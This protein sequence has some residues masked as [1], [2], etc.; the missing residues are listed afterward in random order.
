MPTEQTLETMPLAD[1]IERPDTAAFII[2]FNALAKNYIA[3]H[4]YMRIGKVL[5]GNY[6][7]GYVQ[8]DR[9][10][11]ILS[12]LGTFNI[13]IFP[14]VCGLHA[15]PELDAS[16]ITAVQQQPFLDLR[17]RGVL[18]GFV[19]T[20]IDYTQKAFQYEDGTTKI[21]YIWD[22]TIRGS[23]PDGYNL[24]AEYTEAQINE[25]INSAEPYSVVPHRDTVGHGTFL[26]SVAA[27]RERG[28][29]MGAAP[30]SELIV[31]KLKKASA[32]YTSKYLV[33]PEQENVY[34]TSDLMLGIDYIIE[35]AAEL[36]MPVAICISVGTN[37]GGHDGSNVLEAFLARISHM[38]GIAICAS[39]GNESA[40]RHH[41]HGQV[42]RTGAVE[43]I[44]ITV[45][46]R[47]GSFFINLWSGP[48]DRISVSVRSPAGEVV[49]SIPARSGTTIEQRLLLEHSTVN[50]QYFFPVGDT[51]AQLTEIRI[52]KPTPGFWTIRIHGDFIVSGRY[53]AW[54]P[55]M[56]LG[57]PGISFLPSS[58]NYTVCVPATSAG[59]I[60]CGAY[61]IYTDSLYFTSSWGP[62]RMLPFSPDLAAP[63]V[64]VGGIFPLGYGIMSGTSVA[65]AITTGACALMLQWGYVQRNETSISTFL[66][67][68]ALIRGCERDPRINYPNV[69]WGY[70]KL[71]LLNTFRLIRPLA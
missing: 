63:G 22:Q 62:A 6:A 23:F 15:L 39:A 10:R 2:R 9:L 24:G 50:I 51:G 11:E 69:Q 54:L 36:R 44:E 21:K 17:G 28:T 13:D 18:I 68:T 30:D 40:Q 67:K 29:Y 7:I 53:N 3:S 55:L 47:S 31:V 42:A 57:P 33:P 64:N 32:F 60:T 27:S 45:G 4:P 35:K 37:L 41:T 5:T 61:D 8:R 38:P 71:N 59:V 1:F 49:E 12:D 46:K 43:D 56:G 19:D 65:A 52:L 66:I 70:G 26:A 34:E 16:G 48:S 58:P 25:A 20:G 14:L